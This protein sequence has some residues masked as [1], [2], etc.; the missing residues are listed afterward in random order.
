MV[1]WATTIGPHTARLFERIL[2]DK[3]HPEMGY[4][5][6]LG[7]IRLAN[8][9][10]PERV[11]AAAERALLTGACRY[12]SVKSILENSLD[13]E[14]LAGDGHDGTAPL[15]HDNVRGAEYFQ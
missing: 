13:R 9:Y 15:Y 2:N 14:P 12:K 11:E 3:P 10:S 7:I 5:G 1:N 6:C 4:R 8:Q